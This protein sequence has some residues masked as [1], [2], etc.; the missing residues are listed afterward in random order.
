MIDLVELGFEIIFEFMCRISNSDQT[1]PHIRFIL[2]GI[3]YLIFAMLMGMM[4][5]AAYLLRDNPIAMTITILIIVLLL[6]GTIRF[7]F[8]K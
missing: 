8:K 4:I 3:I 6:A 2:K 5:L 1:K 7:H